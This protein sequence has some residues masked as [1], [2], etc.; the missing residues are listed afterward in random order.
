M[1]FGTLIPGQKFRLGRVVMTRGLMC[2]CEERG[3]D[4][5]T[6]LWRHSQG[7]FGTVGMLDSAILTED[8]LAHGPIATSDDLLLSA[9]AVKNNEGTV[10]SVFE[11]DPPDSAR[12]WIQTILAG[13]NTYTTLLLPE[14]Y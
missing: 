8:V 7:D 11:T 14:E 13:E 10:M 4:I 3:V 5:H 6:M 2:L 1:E 9:L 12:I